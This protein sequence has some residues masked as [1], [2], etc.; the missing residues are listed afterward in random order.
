[1]TITL[2]SNFL[3]IYMFA[4][5]ARSSAVVVH[6]G[7]AV[8]V[9]VVVMSANVR[10]CRVVELVRVQ[11]RVSGWVVVIC[12]VPG[13]LAL[14]VDVVRQVRNAV[15]IHDRLRRDVDHL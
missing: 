5:V 7:R 1:M 15:L 11:N 8:V 6:V 14:D 13:V 2:N 10:V 9:V 3:Q 4:K 12:N